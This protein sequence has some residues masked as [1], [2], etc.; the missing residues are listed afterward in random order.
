MNEHVTDCYIAYEDKKLITGGDYELPSDFDATTREWYMRAK[1]EKTCIFTSAYVDKNT[2]G[3]VI[4]IAEP[5]M[6]KEK[7]IGVIGMDITL[8]EL[9]SYVDDIKVENESYAFLMAADGNLLVHPNAS[10]APTAD[11]YR[12]IKDIHEGQMNKAALFVEDSKAAYILAKDYDNEQKC[13]AM[14]PVS[15][16][17]W[18]LVVTV[19]T[20]ILFSKV[21]QLIVAFCVVGVICSLVMQLI[22][23]AVMNR[24]FVPIATLKQL[25]KGN[26]KEEKAQSYDAKNSPYKDEL[27]EITKETEKVRTQLIETITGAKESAETVGYVIDGVKTNTYTLESYIEKIEEMMGHVTYVTKQTANATKEVCTTTEEIDKAVES[28]AMKASDAAKNSGDI[29]IRA[30]QIKAEAIETQACINEIYDKTSKK[31][32]KALIAS[33]AVKEIDL[34]LET[35][36][37]ISGQTNL[38]ALN[39]SIEAARAGEEGKGFSVVA[40]EI[41]KLAEST[42]QATVRIREVT[43]KVISAM[44]Q[45]SGEAGN[46]LD[47]IRERV[48]EDYKSQVEVAMQYD[49]DAAYYDRIAQELSATTQELNAA[50]LTVV[51]AMSVIMEQN[52]SI[53]DKAQ[54]TAQITKEAALEASSVAEEMGRLSDSSDKLQNMVMKF[55]L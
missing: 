17:G 21:K 1:E 44:D 38:L 27:E 45:M 8:D 5:V 53:T 18:K 36:T 43:D 25:A 32:E 49:E 13:F 12:N 34:L 50:V 19:P 3:L 20:S 51:Q 52:N 47:F 54:E 2:G 39:A 35:I 40:E 29:S 41:R 33:K 23:L 16:T 10:Y 46:L 14:S 28:V 15:A 6:E 48:M 9:V 22:L 26:L 30:K 31:I 7:I 42:K 24:L 55:E 4:T 11:G 37:Q